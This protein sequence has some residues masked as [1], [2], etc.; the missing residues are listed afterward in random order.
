MNI[1]PALITQNEVEEILNK[2]LISTTDRFKLSSISPYT[3]V[4]A[5]GDL[6]GSELYETYKAEALNLKKVINIAHGVYGQQPFLL[7]KLE[8]MPQMQ[9]LFEALEEQETNPFDLKLQKL[10]SVCKVLAADCN[11][12]DIKAKFDG[13]VPAKM[14]SFRQNTAKEWFDYY[15]SYVFRVA[16]TIAIKSGNEEALAY[17]S[18][19]TAYYLNKSQPHKYKVGVNDKSMNDTLYGILRQFT[20][21][22]L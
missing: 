19:V 11:F 13:T 20:N 18:C 1:F 22:Y 3:L 5:I 4:S 9:D 10:F 15:C 2:Q 21:E 12:K 16:A 14:F 17:I 6:K 8:A 7:N